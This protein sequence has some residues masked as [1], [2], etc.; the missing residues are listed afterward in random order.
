MPFEKAGALPFEEAGAL[1]F[2]SSLNEML[3]VLD[4]RMK[5]YCGMMLK[6]IIKVQQTQ[7]KQYL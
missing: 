6:E 5:L 7:S 1:P 4:D 2:V 3:V